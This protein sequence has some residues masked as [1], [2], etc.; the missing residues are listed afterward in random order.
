MIQDVHTA[1]SLDQFVLNF[2]STATRLQQRRRRKPR[3]HRSTPSSGTRI[4][5]LDTKAG[6]RN[7][8]RCIT[9]HRLTNSRLQ[10][11]VYIFMKLSKTSNINHVQYCEECSCLICRATCGTKRQGN[12]VRVQIY[13]LPRESVVRFF[14][15]HFH[16][17][18]RDTSRRRQ[19]DGDSASVTRHATC[20]RGRQPV[21]VD[22]HHSACLSATTTVD[23]ATGPGPRHSSTWPVNWARGW[24]RRRRAHQFH[25]RT[26]ETQSA[27]QVWSPLLAAADYL[28]VHNLC[29]QFRCLHCSQRRESSQSINQS[30][31]TLIHVDRPQRDK[32]HMV[33]IKIKSTMIHNNNN[34]NL[35]M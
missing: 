31:K 2:C 23:E 6:M 18:K 28:V 20:A 21:S 5:L 3:L 27:E 14:G 10:Y 7:V 32:V 13:W 35:N 25:R 30:I 34:L 22:L 17:Q 29:R 19:T 15:L 12:K 8:L 4:V 1:F 16:D 33:K 24:Q 11:T 9:P 26:A